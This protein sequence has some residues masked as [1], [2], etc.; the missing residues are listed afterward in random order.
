[1][2]YGE[3]VVVLTAETIDGPDGGWLSPDGLYYPNEECGHDWAARN[4]CVL[5]WN[6]YPETSRRLDSSDYLEGKG[7]LR[8]ECHGKIYHFGPPT[9]KQLEVLLALRDKAYADSAFKTFMEI[10]VEKAERHFAG[11]RDAKLEQRDFAMPVPMARD[12]TGD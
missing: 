5:L 8:I 4:L 7:W 1:M 9:E 2:P 6:R 10:Y 12:R 3:I 11:Q